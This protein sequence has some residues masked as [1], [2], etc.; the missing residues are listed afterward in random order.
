MGGVRD[1]FFS[2]INYRSKEIF[3]SK[4]KTFLAF[5]FCFIFGASL[6]SFFDNKNLLFYVYISLF[7][8]LFLGII[9]WQDKYKRF[10]ILCLLFFAVG[11]F[12]FLITISSP[13]YSRIEFYN[14]DKVNLQGWISAEPDIGLSDAKYIVSVKSLSGQFVIP[15]TKEESLSQSKKGQRSFANTQDDN[16]KVKGKIIIKTRL[17]PQFNYGDELKI[18]C[19][20]QQPENSVDSSF[21]YV[22]YLAKQGIWSVCLNPK[23]SATG[24]NHGNFLFKIM[25]WLKSKMQ[26]QMARLWPEPENGLMAGVL[27]GS[28]SGLPQDLIDN[29]TRTGVT[30]IIAVSGYNVSIIVAML[31]VCLIYFGLSRRQSFWSLNFLIL[32]FVFFSGATASVVRAGIMAGIV[33]FAQ[34]IGRLSAVGRNLVY[35]VVIMLFFNPYLLVWDAGFQLSFLSTL[36]LVYLSPVLESFVDNKFKVPNWILPIIEVLTTTLSAIAATLPLILFQFGRLSLVAPV[37]NVLVLWLVP[38]LML[39]GFISLILSFFIFPVGQSVAW[40]AGLGLKYV[41]I[42]VSWFGNKSWSAVNINIP[43][44]LMLVVYILLVYFIIKNSYGKKNK[45]SPV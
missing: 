5:C 9:F 25:F 19:L 7:I 43:V 45:S 2:T 11:A 20:L 42:I 23:V 10:F 6:F 22:K 37:V 8:I 12:R 13:D 38:W 31:D 14:G 4:S 39:F 16:E 36:G 29:F 21:N 26:N 24:S 17:Y 44:W 34:H 18:S 28:K 3:E 27:Y 33:L 41:I 1:I 40:V 32:A 35:A 15:T 30:H